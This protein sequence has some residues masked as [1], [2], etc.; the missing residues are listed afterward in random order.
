M[1]I[2]ENNFKEHAQIF[3]PKIIIRRRNKITFRRFVRKI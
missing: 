3:S 2:S 1:N